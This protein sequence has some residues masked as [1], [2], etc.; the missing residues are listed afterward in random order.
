MSASQRSRVLRTV[1]GGAPLS[2]SDKAQRPVLYWMSRDQRVQDN[3]ALHYAKQEALDCGSPLAVVFCLTP[4]F[5][6]ATF[7]AY[8]FMLKGLR[9]TEQALMAVGVPFFLLPG[10]PAKELPAFA[11]AVHSHTVVCDFSPMPVKKMWNRSLLGLPYP[12]EDPKTPTVAVSRTSV[13][14]GALPA[15]VER[16][17]EVDAHNVVPVW[18]TSDKREHAARTIRPKVSA[19]LPKFLVDYPEAHTKKNTGDVLT[20]WPCNAAK[21]PSAIDFD[22]MY[23]SLSVDR[24]VTPASWITPGEKA[25]NA[26]VAAFA[27]STKHL[28]AYETQRNDPVQDAQSQ[29]SPF[30]HFGHAS[31]QRAAFA[32]KRHARTASAAHKGMEGFVEELVVRRELSDNYMYYSGDEPDFPKW[33]LESLA[34]HESDKREYLYSEDQFEFGKTHDELWNA[35]QLQMVVQGKMHGFLRMYWAKKILEWTPNA[36]TAFDIALR[37]ND[38]YELDGR[39]PNGFV[40]VAWSMYGVHDMGWTERSVFGKVR[41]MNYA[42]CKR[43]F[44]IAAYVTKVQNMLELEAAHQPEL[45][46]RCLGVKGP[47]AK[48]TAGGMVQPTIKAAIAKKLPVPAAKKSRSRSPDAAEQKQ[49]KPSQPRAKSK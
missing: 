24:S 39:D 8:D 15:C 44:N 19:L 6:G 9:E 17:V 34:L 14:K 22:G 13:A 5:P 27:E 25:A 16:V 47:A 20:P 7:R 26:A 4:G 38:K 43:K 35:A 33:A 46:A 2:A 28:H 45:V 11:N 49:R 36:A 42:G 29:L 21:Q 3:W 10:D 23:K 1:S 37:L 40:G 48:P 32:A 18:V 31:P 41:Y 30:L 12:P